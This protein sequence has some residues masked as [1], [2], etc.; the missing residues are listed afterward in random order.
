MQQAASVTI[1][2]EPGYLVAIRLF[3]S[4]L[5]AKIGLDIDEI[6]EMKLCTAEACMLLMNQ[7]YSISLLKLE[8]SMGCKGIDVAISALGDFAS[9]PDQHPDD[10]GMGVEIL[11]ALTMGL[12]IGSE[13]GMIKN[14]KFSK[15]VSER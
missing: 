14:V 7:P 9:T 6:E 12:D 5:A 4:A 13:N 8:F 11:E 3:A 2:A 15:N 1:P 10:T